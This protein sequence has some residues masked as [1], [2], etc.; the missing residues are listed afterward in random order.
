LASPTS[1]TQNKFSYKIPD[2]VLSERGTTDLRFS[3]DQFLKAEPEYMKRS[4]NYADIQS[5][6]SPQGTFRNQYSDQNAKSNFKFTSPLLQKYSN[7]FVEDYFHKNGAPKRA[8]PGE[9]QNKFEEERINPAKEREL[10]SRPF[11]SDL[12]DFEHKIVE[13]KEQSPEKGHPENNPYFFS[14]QNIYSP[15]ISNRTAENDFVKANAQV[16]PSDAKSKSSGAPT[17]SYPAYRAQDL[18][19]DQHI[20]NFDD[21]FEDELGSGEGI[22]KTQFESLKQYQPN[23]SENIEEDFEKM[24]MMFDHVNAFYGHPE[25]QSP[26]EEDK[27][28]FPESTPGKYTDFLNSDRRFEAGHEMAPGHE[29]TPDKKLK[30]LTF[31]NRLS[32]E[33]HHNERPEENGH[34]KIN[35]RDL[36]LESKQRKKIFDDKAFEHDK[37]LQEE[38]FN[39]ER[40]LREMEKDN[41][42]NKRVIFSEMPKR[43][44]IEILMEPLQEEARNAHTEE[45]KPNSDRGSK[46]QTTPREQKNNNFSNRD[47]EGRRDS[48]RFPF[49]LKNGVMDPT[50]SF[51]DFENENFLTNE[52]YVK[53]QIS[54]KI[55]DKPSIQGG[56]KFNPGTIQ[57]LSKPQETTRRKGN[58]SGKIWI[59]DVSNVENES[60]DLANPQSISQNLK[61]VPVLK[62]CF[63]KFRHITDNFPHA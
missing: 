63:E 52:D 5:F 46:T 10:Q 55:I 58:V 57:P 23:P 49:Q 14:S 3:Q 50:E 20:E 31:K 2:N 53:Q 6:S 33:R 48:E 42:K 27:M 39:S 54:Q 22:P 30:K 26:L 8:S 56:L 4:A 59:L 40:V 62:H 21:P 60:V 41:E 36:A 37:Q 24:N 12:R 7:P 1:S 16:I 11:N 32:E 43:K 51:F 35:E 28:E 15:P 44:D 47:L 17:L 38:V 9:R 61:K 13:S 34:D 29:T 18:Q 45:N 25:V 19:E